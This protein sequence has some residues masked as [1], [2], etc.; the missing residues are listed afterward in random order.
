MPFFGVVCDEKAT[1]SVVQV[2]GIKGSMFRNGIFDSPV[3][4]NKARRRVE[5]RIESGHASQW[6]AIKRNV[7]RT[8]VS[9]IRIC[10]WVVAHVSI[11][12]AFCWTAECRKIVPI[13]LGRCRIVL[14]RCRT[15]VPTVNGNDWECR[16]IVS[17]VL[18]QRD[19]WDNRATIVQSKR[20][21]QSF[22]SSKATIGTIVR[23]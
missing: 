6:N 19:D 5:G 9:R 21:G 18:I 23:Q 20:F 15:T 10:V 14:G 17:I 4:G 7:D 22:D 11:P 3:L 2:I 8:R 1:G 13:V 16:T 12:V